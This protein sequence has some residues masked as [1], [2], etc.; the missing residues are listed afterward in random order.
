MLLA[1]RVEVLLE[2]CR[3][4]GVLIRIGN[5]VA[6]GLEGL[7]VAYGEAHEVVIAGQQQQRSAG[8]PA[9]SPGDPHERVDDGLLLRHGPGRERLQDGGVLQ[10]AVQG[11][12]DHRGDHAVGLVELPGQGVRAHVSPG[13]HRHEGLLR[14]ND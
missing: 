9:Q 14:G 7:A 12:R 8:F 3:V 11:R 10:V 4:Q 5:G 6:G 13:D 2:G 1:Q